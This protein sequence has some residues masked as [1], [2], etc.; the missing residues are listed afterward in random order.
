VERFCQLLR[1][2][3]VDCDASVFAG[4][5]H[6]LTRNLASQERDFDPDPVAREAGFQ[7]QVRF[8]VKL[9]FIRDGLTSR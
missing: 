4:L 5:G 2:K 7:A 9:G 3:S 8:L 1:G 6:L